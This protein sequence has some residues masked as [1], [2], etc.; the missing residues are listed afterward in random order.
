MILGAI[1]TLCSNSV[2]KITANGAIQI[3]IPSYL[4][5]FVS[6]GTTNYFINNENKLYKSTG[7]NDPSKFGST[8]FQQVQFSQGKLYGL[9]TEGVVKQLQPDDTWIDYYTA[10]TVIF[11]AGQDDYLVIGTSSQVLFQGLCPDY[12]CGV[13]LTNDKADTPTAVNWGFS[14]ADLAHIQFTKYAMIISL[15]NLSAYVTGIDQGQFCT[16]AFPNTI[17]IRDIGSNVQTY[18]IQL[19]S[20][21]D[22]LGVS[23]TKLVGLLLTLSGSFY[24]C[25]SSKRDLLPQYSSITDVAV[26]DNQVTFVSDAFICSNTSTSPM[27]IETKLYFYAMN[28]A[29]FVVPY[30]VRKQTAYNNLVEL[31]LSIVLPVVVICLVVCAII[32]RYREKCMIKHRKTQNSVIMELQTD[33]NFD[34]VA[35]AFCQV[36]KNTQYGSLLTNQNILGSKALKNV[37][38]TQQYLVSNES[39]KSKTQRGLYNQEQAHIPDIKLPMVSTNTLNRQSLDP[40]PDMVL[41]SSKVE[42]QFNRSQVQ[43]DEFAPKPGPV[44]LVP[45]K[46]EE[47]KPKLDPIKVVSPRSKFQK[48]SEPQI[49]TQIVQVKL[50]PNQNGTPKEP[51][52]P[53]KGEMTEALSNLYLTVTQ[54]KQEVPAEAPAAEQVQTISNANGELNLLKRRKKKSKIIEQLDDSQTIE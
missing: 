35:D 16:S 49:E 43:V 9:T 42:P 36:Q 54:D 48:L 53:K 1:Y 5:H 22:S 37:Q 13:K 24:M 23:K 44:Q 33:A 4:I 10:Q 19:V 30:N 17:Y 28:G 52:Q 47:P 14:G 51:E 2:Y 20:Y 38:V 50:E 21:V 45:V 26:I 39:Y 6:D 34:D 31:T 25:D 12:Y 29:S 8:T 27:Q 3:P 7:V 41:Q 40:Q 18:D 32:V 11:L 15:S 46:Y